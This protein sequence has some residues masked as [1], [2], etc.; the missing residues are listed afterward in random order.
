MIYDFQI[1][2]KKAYTQECFERV[3]AKTFAISDVDEIIVG[4]RLAARYHEKQIRSDGNKYIVHPMRVALLLLKYEKAITPPLVIAALLHDTLEDTD[5]TE[6]EV[7][8]NFGETVLTYVQ[9]ATRYREGLQTSNTRKLGKMEKW[10]QTMKASWEI[11]VI[12]TFDYLDNIISMKFI[13]PNMPH[14]KKIPRWLMEAQTMYVPLAE[15][16]SMEAHKLLLQ[17][18]NYYLRKGFQTGDW[19]SG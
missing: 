3:I 15:A 7:L 17:E 8:L 4:L 14:Y 18:I 19:Y 6:S 11:R 13:K 2:H 10:E 16:T 9:G 12:K 1:N 5:L